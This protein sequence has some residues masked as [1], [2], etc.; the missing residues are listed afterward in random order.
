MQLGQRSVNYNGYDYG[1]Y[2]APL[3]CSTNQGWVY[4]G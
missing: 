4:L 1:C 2:N 3:G